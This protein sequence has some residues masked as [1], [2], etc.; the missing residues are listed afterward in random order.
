M[1]KLCLVAIVLVIAVTPLMGCR[2]LMMG[3]AAGWQAVVGVI[4]PVDSGHF[5]SDFG[6]Y[7]SGAGNAMRKNLTRIHQ[8]LD[9]HFLLYDW[10]DPSL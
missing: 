2:A 4:D 5:W 9:H 10:E 1:K 6:D 7:L 8:T 3:T